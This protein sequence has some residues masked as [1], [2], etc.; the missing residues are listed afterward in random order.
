MEA[1]S[2]FPSMTTRRG[3]TQ[4]HVP[5][6]TYRNCTS[7]NS[8]NEGFTATIR[9]DSLAASPS[10]YGTSPSTSSFGGSPRSFN[11]SNGP[12]S[13]LSLDGASDRS[14]G[15]TSHSPRSAT[16]PKKKPSF[17]GFLAVK[18][19]STQAFEAYQ[20]QMKKRGTTQNGRANAVGLPGVSS[21][22]LPPTVP[23]VNSKWDGV[24]QTAKEK[25]KKDSS[26]YR[27]SLSSSAQRPL[28]TSRSTGSNMT[29]MSISSASSGSSTG[30]APRING[31]LRYDNDNQNLS[32]IYGWETPPPSNESSTRSLPLE[33]RGSAASTPTLCGDSPLSYPFHPSMTR[34]A[35]NELESPPLLDPSSDRSSPGFFPA[36]PS[37]ITPNDSLQA[38]PLAPSINYSRNEDAKQTSSSSKED[39]VSFTSSGVNILGPPVSATQRAGT[40][41]S[42]AMEVNRSDEQSLKS[43]VRTPL[44][45]PNSILKRPVLNSAES[46]PMSSPPSDHRVAERAIRTPATMSGSKSKF[47]SVFGKGA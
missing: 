37:P 3:A 35:R 19:P 21:A 39:T 33:P 38:L 26:P 43:P 13:P 16:L 41:R 14:P 4:P 1:V 7:N 23:K 44:S 18:E 27:L 6:L 28:H 2:N 46:W 25:S 45:Q 10:T 20:E 36:L 24:P 11:Y 9:S 31:K 5:K 30:S 40:T 22:K 42:P 34:E 29:G 8:L 32:E 15:S 47:L 12:L 17:F